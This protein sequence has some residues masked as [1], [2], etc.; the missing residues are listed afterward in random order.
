MISLLDGTEVCRVCALGLRVFSLPSAR[1]AKF[2]LLELCQT[3]CPGAS[4]LVLVASE[5][6]RKDISLPNMES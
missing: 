1:F 6:G 5:R 4:C 3:S 2:L